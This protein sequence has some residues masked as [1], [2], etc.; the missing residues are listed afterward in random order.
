MGCG[1]GERYPKM[2]DELED[3]PNGMVESSS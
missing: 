3:V 2:S 1:R